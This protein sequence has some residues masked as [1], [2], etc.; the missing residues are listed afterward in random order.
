MIVKGLVVANHSHRRHH[1]RRGI[2]EVV[3]EVEVVAAAAAV[4]WIATRALAGV[5]SSVTG[6]HLEAKMKVTEDSLTDYHL[7]PPSTYITLVLILPLIVGLSTSTLS[8]IYTYI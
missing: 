8:T 5:C 3:V 6:Y 7:L 2:T 1:R 4:V